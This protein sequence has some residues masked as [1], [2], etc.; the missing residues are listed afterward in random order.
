MSPR[1]RVHVYDAYDDRIRRSRVLLTI[2]RVGYS[3]SVLAL[4]CLLLLVVILLVGCVAG[5]VMALRG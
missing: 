4:A 1:I 3:A 5:V 2:A